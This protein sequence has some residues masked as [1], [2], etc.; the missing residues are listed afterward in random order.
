M[1]RYFAAFVVAI[2]FGVL[3]KPGVLIVVTLVCVWAIWIGIF[4]LLFNKISHFLHLKENISNS[5]LSPEIL[6]LFVFIQWTSFAACF[7]LIDVVSF[8]N[9]YIFRIPVNYK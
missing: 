4:G 3:L 2:L 1:N 6:I 5:W 7:Y 9:T 8:L